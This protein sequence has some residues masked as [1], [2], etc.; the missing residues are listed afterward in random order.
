MKTVRRSF[1]LLLILTLL[2]SS[3]AGAFI[4]TTPSDGVPY[5][6]T[7]AWV[8]HHLGLFQ[9]TGSGLSLDKTLTRAEAAALVT[10]LYGAEKEATSGRPSHPFSDVPAWA[11]P[12]VGWLY[13]KGITKG[14][15]ADAYAPDR[16]VTAE[17]FLLLILRSLGY[18]EG[19]D[20]LYTL[21]G[22]EPMDQAALLNELGIF[23]E[24]QWM[25]YVTG[26]MNGD[27][28]PLPFT[29]NVAAE[30]CLHA[31][32]ARTAGGEVLFTTLP[33]A[34][35][36]G[37]FDVLDLGFLDK[38]GAL[39]IVCRLE[40]A[41]CGLYSFRQGKA[42]LL[43]EDALPSWTLPPE[44]ED[45]S[46]LYS[47]RYAPHSYFTATLA[48]P[49]GTYLLCSYVGGLYRYV[50]E[51][52]TLYKLA[53]GPVACA[54]DLEGGTLIVRNPDF[55]QGRIYSADVYQGGTEISLLQNGA[56]T[57]L[58][59]DL[60]HL[61]LYADSV[62][63]ENSALYFTKTDTVGQMKFRHFTY[64]YKDGTLTVTDFQTDD[65]EFAPEGGE[66]LKTRTAEAVAAEQKRVDALLP[67][68]TGHTAASAVA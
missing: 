46:G 8:L 64:A 53:S 34:E 6:Q 33:A 68:W 4:L 2:L 28:K 3:P 1:A 10:R 12:Y 41:S 39:L 29:R 66:Q 67:F 14:V 57:V 52:G 18:R 15:S 20:G 43:S 60:D 49:N 22:K 21:P 26:E 11:D 13:Q 17:Q 65:L 48:E 19:A 7:D 27:K 59:S 30:V 58:V 24:G 42:T 16:A 62:W 38:A 47:W 32:S 55:A 54:S 23:Y 37:D 63:M 44:G 51:Q 31:L 56:E 5:E 36:V 35:Q 45:P 50:P 40:D 25:M 9:G 61:N